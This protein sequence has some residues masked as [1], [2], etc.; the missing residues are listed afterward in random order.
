M[1]FFNSYRISNIAMTMVKKNWP[2]ETLVILLLIESSS[3]IHELA[4]P[5]FHQCSV[6]IPV[7]L[8]VNGTV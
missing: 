6:Q 7:K 8:D 1:F 4:S 5:A 2:S 3:V